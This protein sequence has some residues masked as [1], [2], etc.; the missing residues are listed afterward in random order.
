[1]DL[2]ALLHHLLQ[3]FSRFVIFNH[4]KLLLQGIY[5]LFLGIV[6]D[7]KC[8]IGNIKDITIFFL[9]YVTL[10]IDLAMLGGEILCQ[11]LITCSLDISFILHQQYLRSF[12][13]NLQVC[14]EQILISYITITL[15]F[16]TYF[17]IFMRLYYKFCSQMHSFAPSMM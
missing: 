6:Y 14:S 8:V 17:R 15:F 2:L 12:S 9:I 7:F 1:M 10:Q 3:E 16:S 13:A 5:L 4:S 11:V